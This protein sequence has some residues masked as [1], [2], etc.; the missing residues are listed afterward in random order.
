MTF[1]A[2]AGIISA[3]NLI[4]YQ[5]LTAWIDYSDVNTITKAYGNI[6]QT[7]SGTSGTTTIT[8]SS[9]VANIVQIGM[10]IRIGGTDIYTVSNVVTTTITTVE[11]LSA[12][13][14]AG[15]ALA[16]DQISQVNDKSG[17]GNNYTQ[18][19]NSKKPV[20]TPSIL[21]S[22]PVAIF[23]G[24]NVMAAPS[25]LFSLPNGG[26]T[27]FVVSKRNT[28]TGAQQYITTLTAGGVARRHFRY[29]GT[30]GSIA[31]WNSNAAP[32][33]EIAKT[34]NT[35]TNFNIIRGLRNGTTLTVAVNNGSA[36][37][38]T[39]GASAS[40]VDGGY[41]GSLTDASSW[42]IG[43]VA[44]EIDYNRVLT[45]AEIIQVNRYLSAKYAITIS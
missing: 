31:F 28:E 37:S 13:Y 30:A 14:T 32:G 22:K 2:L 9:T 35:N 33:T 42:L 43:A 23:N 6:S 21:N 41:I 18:S 5:G 27:S 4:P 44:E 36:V 19:T 3:S 1:S 7:G 10:K 24:A 20:Y 12:T 11:T 26:N 25:G 17:L 40:D 39:N 38:N 16:L 45:A 34:G 8:A 29:A 15:S